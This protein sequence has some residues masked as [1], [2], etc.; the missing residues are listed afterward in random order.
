M[1]REDGAEEQAVHLSAAER[2]VRGRCR[3]CSPAASALQTYRGFLPAFPTCWSASSSNAMRA[4]SP[5]SLTAT[6][7]SRSSWCTWRTARCSAAPASPSRAWKR[8]SPGMRTLLVACAMRPVFTI[9][10][11]YFRLFGR[12]LWQHALDCAHACRVFA[13]GSAVMERLPSSLVSSTTWE[14]WWCYSARWRRSVR[15]RPRRHCVP[16]CFSSS[17]RNSPPG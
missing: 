3:R 9:K 13:C 1:R 8:R 2:R 17:L 14:N 16:M 4:R 10:P 12:S 15:R 5:P 11:V 6:R 7:R